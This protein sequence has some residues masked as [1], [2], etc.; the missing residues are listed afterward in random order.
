MSVHHLLPIA[1]WLLGGTW[2]AKCL[3]LYMDHGLVLVIKYL[4]C[5]LMGGAGMY[6]N[7]EGLVSGAEPRGVWGGAQ[8]RP[9]DI[10]RKT[11]PKQL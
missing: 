1:I 9:P 8:P 5:V 4:Y 11:M 3:I 7:Q 6:V 10:N 2:V